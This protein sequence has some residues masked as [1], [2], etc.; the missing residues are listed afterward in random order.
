LGSHGGAGA[1]AT[2]TA[3]AS[4]TG[5][6]NLTVSADVIGGGGGSGYNGASGGN[7]ASITI[8]APIVSGSTGGFLT[9]TQVATGGGG[10]GLGNASSTG[11]DGIAGTSGSATSILIATN[12]GGGSLIA[13]STANAG[14]GGGISGGIAGTAGAGAVATTQVSAT[15]ASSGIDVGAYGIANGGAGGYLGN[16]NYGYPG[17]TGT[18]GAG[19]N[20]SGSATASA[21]GSNNT[22]IAIDTVTGGAGGGVTANGSITV[23]GPAGN[24]G[25]ATSI[26]RATATGSN[27]NI[28]VT[29]A[30]SGGSGGSVT[31]TNG[32]TAIGNGGNGAA[33]SSSAFGSTANGSTIGLPYGLNGYNS[34]PAQISADA[35]GGSGGQ[36]SGLG[37]HGGTGGTATAIASGTSTGGGNLSVIAT[38]IGGNG[39]AGIG[40]ANGGAGGAASITNSVGDS[41]S[42]SVTLNLTANGGV[43]GGSNTGA[44]GTGGNGYISVSSYDAAGGAFAGTATSNGGAG[45]TSASG[46]GGNG[47]AGDAFII[48]GETNGQLTA[49]ANAY[50][51]SGGSG[52]T[53]G[54]V[55]AAAADAYANEYGFGVARADA[56]AQGSG[57]GE[58]LTSVNVTGSNILLQYNIAGTSVSEQVNGI[59][60]VLTAG[61][62]HSE[63]IGSISQAAPSLAQLSGIQSA[64]YGT[65]LPTAS[66]VAGVLTSDPNSTA[67]FKNVD[68]LGLVDLGGAYTPGASGTQTYTSQA[69]FTFPGL[70]PGPLKLGL[71]GSS[72]VGSGFSSLQFTAEEGG[73]ILLSK[74]FTTLAA[75]QSYFDDNPVSITLPA[76]IQPTQYV[77]F[78]LALTSTSAGSGFAGQFIFGPVL[79]PTN[80]YWSGAQNSVWNT[81]IEPGDSTNWTTAPSGGVDTNQVPGAITDVYFTANSATNISTTLGRDFAIKGLF[82]TGAGTAAGSGS[83]TIGGTNTLTI[84]TD[85]ITAQAGT[86]AHTISSKVALGASETWTNNS[87]SLLT[88]SGQTSG[89]F[90]LVKSGTGALLLSGPNNYSGGTRLAAGTLVIGSPT[91]LGGG[92]LIIGGGALDTVSAGVTMTNAIPIAIDASFAFGGTGNLNLGAGGIADGSNYTITLNGSG[93]TL[94][95]GGILTNTLAGNQTTTVLG[96]GNTLSLGGYALSNSATSYNDVFGGNAN[97]TITGPVSNGGTATSSGLTFASSGTLTLDASNSFTGG[98]TLKNG[99][100][101]VGNTYALG[102]VT[103]SVA[104]NLGTLNLNGF[105]PTAGALS[106][107]AG[108][109]ITNN[110]AGT[111]L[112]TVNTSANTAYGGV[113]VNGAGSLGLVKSGTG[114]LTLSGSD[115]YTSGTLINAGTLQLGNT[116]ALGV[117]SGNLTVNGGTL[118]LAGFSPSVGTLAGNAGALITNSAAG[119]ATLTVNETAN[120]TYAGTLA[121]GAGAVALVK[122][123]AYTLTLSASNHYSG[124]TVVNSG[125]L[126]LGNAFALG[127]TTG[128]LAVNAGTVNLAGFSPTVGTLSGSAGGII[129]NN[130][131]GTATL[132]ASSSSSATYAGLLINGSGALAFV[133]NGTG[134][135]TLSGSNTYSGGTTID[136]GTLQLGN[137]FGLGSATGSLAVN[138]GTLNLNGFSPTVGALSGGAAGVITTTT[139]V[140]FTVNSSANTAYAGAINNGA[141]TLELVKA[142]TGTLTLSGS[143]HYSNGTVIDAGA[144]ELGNLYALGAPANLTLNAGTLDLH[145]FSPSVGTLTGSNGALVTSAAA[146]L[147]TLTL[148]ESANTTYAGSLS[149]GAG[150]FSLIKNGAAT[151]TLSGSSHYS[152]PTDVTAGSL[153]ITGFLNTPASSFTVDGSVNAP[154][155]SLSAGASMAAY[156]LNVGFS[157]TGTFTQSGGTSTV[158]NSL[159]LGANAGSS[160]AFTLSAGSLATPYAYVGYSGAGS[161]TQS[162]GLAAVTLL[163]LGD[164]QGSSGVYALKGGTLSTAIVAGGDGASVFDFNGGVLQAS[165]ADSSFM[166]GLATA[167]VQ[168]GGAFVNTNGFADTI[169]QPLLHDTTSGAPAIDGG[170]T[171]QGSGTLTLTGDNTYT[172]PT[173]VSGGTLVDSGQLARTGSASIASGATLEVDGVLNHSATTTDSGTMKGS[174]SVGAITVQAGGAL[175]PGFNS[176]AGVAG[177]LRAYGN[178]T[179]AASTS[180]FSIRL[181]VLTAS[182]NDSLTLDSGN[183]ALGG[184]NLEL[185]LGGAFAPQPAGFIYVIINGLTA[186]SAITG[187]FAQGSSITASNGDVFDIAYGENATDTGAGHDVL[188]IATNDPAPAVQSESLAFTPA[189]ASPAAVF[190]SQKQLVSVAAVP[191]PGAWAMLLW[192]FAALGI[193]RSARRRGCRVRQS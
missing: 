107:S 193:F 138:G 45:G 130:G 87:A 47:G 167:N 19:G 31:Q 184:A 10:G 8:P 81:D 137:T 5:G 36:G 32:G 51:G 185:T 82:F 168:A 158:A 156:S 134:T 115:H 162:G 144:L 27:S 3:S 35:T 104:I 22:V 174:G 72:S 67:I 140:I 64:S 68:V 191:E 73:T 84:G 154:S 74:T 11:T 109:L 69:S 182:D 175:E 96:P 76:S 56:T 110:A 108:G 12:P 98:I 139:P 7:G 1:S 14:S 66:E 188:L 145:G 33:A 131:A 18:A 92:T 55:G 99:T 90:Q 58:A 133:K 83:V 34:F 155:A 77:E 79:T 112:F 49:T 20:A 24:G 28:N 53:T 150:K 59:S 177:T 16:P 170:L 173:T 100:L 75:A 86:A 118:N 103:G 62:S 189:A 15:S 85:G 57:G 2:G 91:A 119:P 187:E 13:N 71:L 48:L 9:L 160:G 4:T 93:K 190:G 186:D 29:D 6:G 179:L 148:S 127:A 146:G 152:G 157:G 172:G 183:V 116:Y 37:N 40:G 151:L 176:V 44:A 149:D 42:G 60:P 136:A 80:A 105:S 41:T 70:Q 171:K 106:G 30:A 122:G 128:S 23:S 61:A 147:A 142:G 143:N 132:T 192:G 117:P 97:V 129:I 159:F 178:V 161:F 88:V 141:G 165:A 153:A 166:T 38:G 169:T 111:V 181:G 121:D 25:T 135:L 113:I 163:E 164:D 63:A 21:S 126:Q 50:G 102:A 180:N 124:G 39:G 95:M 17:T 114:T 94:T 52:A 43:G 101:Q 46:A 89:A 26:S 78:Q 123:G 125:T 65:M 120:T 54:S